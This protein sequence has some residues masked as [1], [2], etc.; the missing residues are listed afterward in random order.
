V[1]MTVGALLSYYGQVACSCMVPSYTRFRSQPEVR[2]S[3]PDLQIL[4][5]SHP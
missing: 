4:I 3:R 2:L 1:N 5:G